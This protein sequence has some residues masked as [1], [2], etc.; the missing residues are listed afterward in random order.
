MCMF[1]LSKCIVY[2]C[3]WTKRTDSDVSAKYALVG[4]Y[5]GLF[6]VRE[7]C[8]CFVAYSRDGQIVKS[9]RT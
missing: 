3:L 5:M 6:P 1:G 7:L 2:I 8:M 4:S 9:K